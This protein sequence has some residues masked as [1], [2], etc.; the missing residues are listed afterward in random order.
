MPSL[1][2][3]LRVVRRKERAL[4]QAK[5]YIGKSIALVICGA[6]IRSFIFGSTRY[7]HFDPASL[8]M[9]LFAESP[10]R[11]GHRRI[12]EK[13]HLCSHDFDAQSI[14]DCARSLL[15]PVLVGGMICPHRPHK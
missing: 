9:V 8:P 1:L 13:Q 10:D 15:M 2:E 3:I 5:S 11:L 7:N 6:A 14:F 4:G 12:G